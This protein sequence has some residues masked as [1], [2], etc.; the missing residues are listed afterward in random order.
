[1]S[2]EGMSEDVAYVHSTESGCKQWFENLWYRFKIVAIIRTNTTFPDTFLGAL[3]SD[4][5]L[6]TFLKL[7]TILVF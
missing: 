2:R 1:M 6:Q 7:V 3:A 4:H 5:F